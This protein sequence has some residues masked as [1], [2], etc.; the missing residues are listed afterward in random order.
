LEKRIQGLLETGV[1]NLRLC[2]LHSCVKH[3]RGVKAWTRGCDVLRSEIVCFVR[4]KLAVA[5]AGRRVQ[6]SIR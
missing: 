1:E 2:S 4:E 3:L 6:C 5:G